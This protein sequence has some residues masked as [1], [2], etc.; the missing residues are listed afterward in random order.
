[1][2]AVV[3]N[4]DIKKSEV[5]SIMWSG[6]IFNAEIDKNIDIEKIEV[7]SNVEIVEFSGNIAIIRPKNFK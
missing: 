4:S 3:V 2:D 5:G 6:A 1:M 7:N